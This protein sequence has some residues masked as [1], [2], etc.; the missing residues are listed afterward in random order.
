MT[1]AEGLAALAPTTNGKPTPIVPKGPGIEPVAGDKGRDRLAA[2]IEDL[3]PV[4]RE[5]SPRAA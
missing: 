1:C 5:G 4:D 2:E 3:L